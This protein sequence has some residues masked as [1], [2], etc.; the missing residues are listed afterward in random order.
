M[1]FSETFIS[2]SEKLGVGL[3]KKTTTKKQKTKKKKKKKKERKKKTKKKKKTT[4]K[5]LFIIS[6]SPGDGWSVIPILT[7]FPVQYEGI[8]RFLDYE[9]LI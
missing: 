1:L 8:F 5:P 6:I 4:N 7:S 3:K 2:T 9:I